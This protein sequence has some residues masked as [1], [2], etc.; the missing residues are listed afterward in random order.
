VGI[1][2]YTCGE[3]SCAEPGSVGVLVWDGE[4]G[5]FEYVDED[6][7]RSFTRHNWRFR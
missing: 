2:A 4:A 1:S 5:T 6:W 7:L 3:R